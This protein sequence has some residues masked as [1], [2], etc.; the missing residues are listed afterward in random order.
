[1]DEEHALWTEDMEENISMLWWQ[2]RTF[3]A[4]HIFGFEIVVKIVKLVANPVAE[5]DQH[6]G[7]C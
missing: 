1:M 6:T 7:Q 4:Y 5:I 2:S 3:W